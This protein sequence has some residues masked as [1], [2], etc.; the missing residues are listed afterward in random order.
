MPI[1][2]IVEDGSNVTNANSYVSIIDARLYCS[3]RGVSLSTND[4]DVAVMIIKACD[5]IESHAERFQGSTLTADQA[6]SWPRIGVYAFGF[7]VPSNSIPPRLK[8]AQC[9]A[10]L[11]VSQGID[12]LPTR[13]SSDYVTEETVGPLT[14]K[15]SD[16]L[17]RSAKPTLTN[18]DALL[19]PLLKSGPNLKTTRV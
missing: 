17:Q 12:L 8:T 6:L 19:M 10:V 13:T 7:E 11:A 4:D 3:Q 5:F 16:P 1:S 2:I 15:Y 9:A 18:V 14:T